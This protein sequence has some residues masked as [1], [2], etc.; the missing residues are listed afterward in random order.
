MCYIKISTHSSVWLQA[1]NSHVSNNANIFQPLLLVP[2]YYSSG[3]HF[4]VEIFCCLSTW[5]LHVL[6]LLHK[7]TANCRG[8]LVTAPPIKS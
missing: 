4:S 1:N 2:N 7:M 8:E 3:P 5:F 6:Y